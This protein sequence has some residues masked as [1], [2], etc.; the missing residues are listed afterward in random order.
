[1]NGCS[2]IFCCKSVDVDMKCRIT[3]KKKISCL[4]FLFASHACAGF[5]LLEDF[6]FLV[7][8][9]S[10]ERKRINILHSLDVPFVLPGFT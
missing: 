6:L 5:Q 7:K 10:Q 4:L 3:L 9:W 1:M 8:L 2:K